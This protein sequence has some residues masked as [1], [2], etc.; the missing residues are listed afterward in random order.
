MRWLQFLLLP[1]M[2]EMDHNLSVKKKV[3]LHWFFCELK[4]VVLFSDADDA[5]RYSTSS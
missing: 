2:I 4:K 3:F 1:P 5:L